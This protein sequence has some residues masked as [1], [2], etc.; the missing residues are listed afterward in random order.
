MKI[1]TIY[2]LILAAIG[3]GKT[4]TTLYAR[5]VVI[6]HG[7]QVYQLQQEK[8]QLQQKKLALMTSL[9]EKNSILTLQ[10]QTDLSAYEPIA[11]PIVL[12][13]RSLASSQL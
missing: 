6:N 12:T 13:L 11:T 10:D 2:Y 3:V 4:L 5:S 7:N 1:I 8:Y 9:S